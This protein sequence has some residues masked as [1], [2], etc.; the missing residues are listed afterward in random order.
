MKIES[1]T[2]LGLVRKENE[3]SIFVDQARGYYIVADG[4]GG[5]RQGET[6]SK[7]AVEAA[8]SFLQE[9]KTLT[10]EEC[11]EGSIQAANF[12]VYQEN[13]KLEDFKNN[14]EKVGM[15]TT[16]LVAIL[17]GKDLFISHVG[18]TRA[19]AYRNGKLEQLT[20]DHSFVNQLLDKGLI[21]E[22]EALVHPEKNVLMRALGFNLEIKG[23]T[24]RETVEQDTCFLFCSD[25]VYNFIDERSLL[26]IL[27]QDKDLRS[28]VAEI[29]AQILI[30][31]AKDNY[32]LIV[33][34]ENKE[35]A[36]G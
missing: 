34:C 32:S 8:V 22:A 9:Q 36:N 14:P 26:S 24:L 21:T 1:L 15:G 31:G 35:V 2:G 23:D 33:F 17:A 16:I 25:G 13:C 29:E 10:I 3:D 20:R 27:Q 12:A 11:L 7:L 18:D 6:A 5:H 28:K 4:M 30:N 19:Y